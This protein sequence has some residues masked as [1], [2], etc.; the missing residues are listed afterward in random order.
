MS[1]KFKENVENAIVKVRHINVNCNFR[2]ALRRCHLWVVFEGQ[3]R[4]RLGQVE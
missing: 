3:E 4:I 2:C 1:I